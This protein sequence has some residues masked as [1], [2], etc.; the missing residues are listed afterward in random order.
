ME[1]TRNLFEFW[2][3]E[4]ANAYVSDDDPDGGIDGRTERNI[5]VPRRIWL[6]V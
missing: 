6:F 2:K 5:R 4:A 3:I 1:G